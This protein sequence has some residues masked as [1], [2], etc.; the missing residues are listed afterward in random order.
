VNANS[1]GVSL[2]KTDTNTFTFP[3]SSFTSSTL[4]KKSLKGPSFTLTESPTLNLAS[5]LGASSKP[6]LLTL[7]VG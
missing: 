1:N 3:C 2:P 7:E 5:N 6:V 4:P